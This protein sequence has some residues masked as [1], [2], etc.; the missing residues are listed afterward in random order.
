MSTFNITKRAFAREHLVVSSTVKTLTAS[1]YE[2]HTNANGKASAAKI[3][4]EAQP[5]RYTEEGTDPVIT[6]GS[7]VG[8]PAVADT[9]IYL[10]SYEAIQKFK[11][12]RNTGTDAHIEVVYYR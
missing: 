10:D 1:V 9:V 6:G 12:L 8:T 11:A 4:V 5:I 3:I 7:E 2:D